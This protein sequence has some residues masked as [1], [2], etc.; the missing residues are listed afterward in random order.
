MKYVNQ[1]RKMGGVSIVQEDDDVSIGIE[2][3]QMKGSLQ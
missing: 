3:L 2:I 1:K